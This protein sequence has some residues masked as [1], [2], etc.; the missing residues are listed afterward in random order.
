[1]RET[2]LFE[3]FTREYLP[4][5]CKE[6]IRKFLTPSGLPGEIYGTVLGPAQKGNLRVAPERHICIVELAE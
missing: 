2:C 5:R 1:M 6:C 3:D 4:F